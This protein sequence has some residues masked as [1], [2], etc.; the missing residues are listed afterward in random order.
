M[1]KENAYASRWERR[2]RKQP[3]ELAGF[4]KFYLTLFSPATVQR[5]YPLGGKGKTLRDYLHL[6]ENHVIIR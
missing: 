5:T 3:P 6:E 2:I 4:R 1:E